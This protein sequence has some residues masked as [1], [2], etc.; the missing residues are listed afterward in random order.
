MIKSE[1]SEKAA[2][3]QNARFVVVNTRVGLYEANS[4]YDQR[5]FT[6]N[7][8]D[9]RIYASRAMGAAVADCLNA[10][11]SNWIVRAAAPCEGQGGPRKYRM[12]GRFI[13]MHSN[14]AKAF[15][16]AMGYTD[17]PGVVKLERLIDG[18]WYEWSEFMS[19]DKDG[20]WLNPRTGSRIEGDE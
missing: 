1:Q 5:T 3:S 12:D 17:G 6:N 20:S 13:E 2:S 4:P 10:H 11:G 16:S 14:D 18:Q 19:G 7:P 8:L 9:A 15:E